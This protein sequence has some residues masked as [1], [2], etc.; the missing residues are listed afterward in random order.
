VFRRGFGPTSVL[1]PIEYAT[2]GAPRGGESLFGLAGTGIA[3][4]IGFHPV[5]VSSRLLALWPLC[6]LAAFFLLGRR[7]SPKGV[8]LVGIASAPFVALLVALALER[9]FE[10]PFAFVWTAPAIPA[11]VVGTARAISLVAPA[12]SV[13]RVVTA[14]VLLVLAI[15]L[16][17]QTVRARPSDRFDISRVAEQVGREARPGDTIVYTPDVVGDIVRFHAGRDVNVVDLERAP[18][19]RDEQARVFIIGAFAFDS[20]RSS[21]R[22]VSVVRRLS[23]DNEL[24]EQRLHEDVT[25]WVVQ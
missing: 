14:L 19:G 7:W 2:P 23:A 15:A 9:P 24:D 3:S 11:I 21:D 25:V 1:P 20:G 6:M 17:D 18:R 13:A 22:T 4:I 16:V 12:W 8:L 5:D 10:P